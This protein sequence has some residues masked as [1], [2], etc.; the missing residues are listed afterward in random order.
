MINP[1]L[2]T[3][4]LMQSIAKKTRNTHKKGISRTDGTRVMFSLGG[5]GEGGGGRGLLGLIFAGYVRHRTH[6][7]FPLIVYSVA[8]Y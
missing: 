2:E 1:K 8:K 7:P 5:R 3:I 6:T 4:E